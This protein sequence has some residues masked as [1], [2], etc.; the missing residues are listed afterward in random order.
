MFKKYL[1]KLVE[2]MEKWGKEK[3]ISEVK[4]GDELE[5][6]E[7]LSDRV[8]ESLLWYNKEW[9]CKALISEKLKFIVV[10]IICV[11]HLIHELFVL[12]INM[13]L[14]C[15]KII[16]IKWWVV[17]EIWLSLQIFRSMTFHLWQDWF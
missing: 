6:M 7:K 9:W 15:L 10:K 3:T 5:Y 14:V 8:S 17:M 11:E 4:L 12:D 1:G 2:N 13:W 16:D